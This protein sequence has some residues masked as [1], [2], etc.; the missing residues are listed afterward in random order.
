MSYLDQIESLNGDLID[1]LVPV[2]A[3]FRAAMAGIFDYAVANP[4]QGVAATAQ[5]AIA[6][7]FRVT[8]ADGLV[9]P[10]IT[11]EQAVTAF[12]NRHGTGATANARWQSIRDWIVERSLSRKQVLIW[13]EQG[14][15]ATRAEMLL[16]RMSWT[17]GLEEL[18]DYVGDSVYTEVRDPNGYLTQE[19]YSSASLGRTVRRITTYADVGGIKTPTVGPWEVV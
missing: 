19:Q 11:I 7:A 2:R 5:T 15:I 8:Y 14:P 9:S 4:T 17:P 3:R 1:C 18:A 10:G 16:A 6:S 13:L 12:N